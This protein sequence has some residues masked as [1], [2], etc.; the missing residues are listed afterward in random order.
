MTGVLIKGGHLD[1]EMH[2][3]KTMRYREKTAAHK[4]RR[5][6]QNRSSFTGLGRN[7]PAHTSISG[8]QPP[9]LWLKPQFVVLC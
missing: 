3:R 9:G 4:L 1:T 5:E 7:N 2:R 6:A 8:F